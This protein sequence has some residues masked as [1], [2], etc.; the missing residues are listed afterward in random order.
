[1]SNFGNITY[2]P[3][4]YCSV[5]KLSDSLQPHELQHTRLFCPSLSPRVCS[6]SHPLSRLCHPTTLSSVSPVS[7]LQSFPASRSFPLSRFFTPDGQST[8]SSASASNE[9]SVLIY[10]RIDQFDFLGVQGTLKS[11]LQHHSSKASILQLSAFFMV[12]LSY[13]YMTTGKTIALTIQTFVSIVMSCNI[14]ASEPPTMSLRIQRGETFVLIVCE[15][16]VKHLTGDTH[17]AIIF[18]WKTA[19][20]LNP[21]NKGQISSTD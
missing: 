19:G 10:F 3:N 5:T 9:Y 4:C 8:G 16:S 7:C 12:Q 21:P 20:L 15:V 2:L 18:I 1:M 11:L 14:P 13:P 6:S 17:L